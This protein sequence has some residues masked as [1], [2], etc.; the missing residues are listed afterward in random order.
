M[1]AVTLRF[2]DGVT[3]GIAVAPGQTV[4]DAALAQDAPLLFQCRSGSCATCI[5][6]L[7]HGPATMRPGASVLLRHEAEA[8]KRLLCQT[9]VA[10]PCDFALDYAS[11]AGGNRPS[12][13]SAFVDSVDRVAADVVR[14][15][16]ELAS[17]DSFDFRPGQYVQLNVPGT[18]Q[19]RSY[20]IA[21]TPAD[22][23][24]IELL[25]RLI[26]GGIMSD[27]LGRARPDDV[28]GLEA[29]FGSFFL[30]DGLRAPQIMIA[31]GTGLA[32][33][34]SMIDSI[35]ARPGI[36]PPILLSFGCATA[37]GLFHRDEL[38]LRAMW[39]PRLQVRLSVDAGAD[40][41]AGSGLR[42]G[43]P[44]TAITAADVEDPETRAWLCGPPGLIEAGHRHLTALGLPAARIHAEQ[45]VASQ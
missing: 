11:T 5:A 8:G 10:G 28:V 22:L 37:A 36:K 43:N 23:P 7:A 1:H 27:W 24:G 4:L 9:L 40:D 32:P 20:S 16:L 41:A 6:D 12:R 30:P 21:S 26:P 13:V 17:G 35:R 38:D 19:W 14:L 34:L 33:M 18:E 45:F 31:G 3:L 42:T 2:R 15:V 25:I 44:V 39:M 29:P